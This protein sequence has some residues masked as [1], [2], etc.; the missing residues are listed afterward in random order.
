MRPKNPVSLSLGCPIP[1]S[2]SRLKEFEKSRIGD[3]VSVSYPSSI[4]LGI[5]WL[6]NFGLFFLLVVSW[7][8]DKKEGYIINKKRT[9]D[10]PCVYGLI[11]PTG[12]EARRYSLSHSKAH[13]DWLKISILEWEANFIMHNWDPNK[14][15]PSLMKPLSLRK[16]CYRSMGKLPSI[17]SHMVHVGRKEIHKAGQVFSLNL[18]HPTP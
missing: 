15:L 2:C 16:S 10:S 8:W 18:R 9:L 14:L 4:V 11:T 12:V 13:I 7:I 6:S 5:G 3:W 17:L 1:F